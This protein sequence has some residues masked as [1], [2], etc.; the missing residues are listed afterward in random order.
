[1]PIGSAAVRRE[2]RDVTI[3][4]A[5]VM[6]PRAL[7][8]AV[9]LAAENI[10]AE[11][12]DLRSLRPL[13]SATIGASVRKTHRLLVVHEGVKTMG[14]G[15]EIAARIAESDAFAQLA[16]PI[17]RLGGADVPIPYNPILEKAAVPQ[18]DDIVNAAHA[19][20]RRQTR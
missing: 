17:V 11:V 10:D 1:V 18:E 4:A 2:G 6:T 3:V 13:D 12:I 20:A 15:A 8:A 19:L 9:R 5:S 14:I 7:A 16:A